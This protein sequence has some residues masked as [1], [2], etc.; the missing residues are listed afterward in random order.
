MVKSTSITPLKSENINNAYNTR[1]TKLIWSM[2][3]TQW[4]S[5]APG[6][7][8]GPIALWSQMELSEVMHGS[9]KFWSFWYCMTVKYD[10]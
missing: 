3:S 10:L 9:S 5:M 6:W 7:S 4:P 8:H 2:Y 1:Q